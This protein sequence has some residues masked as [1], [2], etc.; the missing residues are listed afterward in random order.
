LGFI[1]RRSA[2][3]WC[4]ATSSAPSDSGPTTGQTSVAAVQLALPMDALEPL[5][6]STVSIG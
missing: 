5:I 2:P 4:P 3:A 1:R 6:A